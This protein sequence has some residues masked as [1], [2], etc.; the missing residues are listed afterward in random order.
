MR[1]EIQVYEDNSID[2]PHIKSIKFYPDPIYGKLINPRMEDEA[3]VFDIS[4]AK[5]EPIVYKENGN[6]MLG[7]QIPTDFA[8]R[9]VILKNHTIKEFKQMG[10]STDIEG[11]AYII[12]FN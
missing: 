3:I 8:I 4:N 1:T 7:T 10:E 11:I 6:T 9:S 2:T 5:G 12:Y